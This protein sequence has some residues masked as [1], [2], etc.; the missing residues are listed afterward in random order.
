MLRPHGFLHFLKRQSTCKSLCLYIHLLLNSAFQLIF[1]L[2]LQRNDSVSSTESF[3]SYW[4]TSGSID[5]EPLCQ[6]RWYLILRSCIKLAII[7]QLLMC[8]DHKCKWMRD[9]Q[10]PVFD[11]R[12]P[13]VYKTWIAELAPFFC[14]PQLSLNDGFLNLENVQ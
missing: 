11:L 1:V 6:S 3:S 5:R 2:I 10:R 12:L 13:W 4:T 8:Q 14:P 7:W 9:Q